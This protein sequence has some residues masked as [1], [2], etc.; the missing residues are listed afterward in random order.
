MN[1]DELAANITNKLIARM[2]VAELAGTIGG[3][4]TG[5]GFSHFAPKNATTGA[6]YQGFNVVALYCAGTDAEHPTAQ[7]AT[8]KQW[9]GQDA[10]VA[11]GQKGTQIVKWISLKANDDDGGP[12]PEDKT[13]TRMIPRVYTCLLYTSPSPRDRG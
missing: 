4:W 13:K 1:F 12:A 2:E 3:L 11:Q 6:H 10:Q 9:K 5:G 7:W 8:Y